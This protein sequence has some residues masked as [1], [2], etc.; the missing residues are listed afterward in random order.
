MQLGLLCVDQDANERPFMSTIVL[1][2]SSLT[3]S[4]PLPREPRYFA[5]NDTQSHCPVYKRQALLR[6]HDRN[7]KKGCECNIYIAE[8]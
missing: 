1:T 2:L 6:N 4:I 7:L 3:A 8:V 5:S